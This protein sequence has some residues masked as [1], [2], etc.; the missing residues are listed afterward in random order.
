MGRYPG[1]YSDDLESMAENRDIGI[2]YMDHAGTTPLAPEV[3]GAM[4]P[5]FTQLFGN[6]SSIHTVG[7][8]ARY[9]LG[10][11]PGTGG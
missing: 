11:G 7:Q 9:A 1:D 4:T 2:V 10:R 6:P 8:E 3:L 5:Y